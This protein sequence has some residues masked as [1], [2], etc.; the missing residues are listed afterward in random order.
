MWL[1]NASSAERPSDDAREEVLGATKAEGGG[2][3]AAGRTR[4]RA[5]ALQGFTRGRG[6]RG[7]RTCGGARVSR[8]GAGGA[9]QLGFRG[10]ARGARVSRGGAGG[11]ALGFVRPGRNGPGR[12]NGEAGARVEQAGAGRAERTEETDI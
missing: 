10:G 1:E 6:G 9:A 5:A 7:A 8:G 4:G 11:A 2:D 12:S 3:V